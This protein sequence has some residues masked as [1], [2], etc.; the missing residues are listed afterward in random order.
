MLGPRARLAHVLDRDDDAKVELLPRAGVDDPDRARP[1]HE[2]SDFL[3]RALG[4]RQPDA[5]HRLAHEPVKP[6]D[7]EREVRPALR[8]GNRVDL[9]EDQRPGRPQHLAALR[10]EQQVERLRGRDQDVGR[11]AEHRR[12]LLLRGVAGPHGDCQLRLEPGERSAQVPLDVVVQRLQGRDVQE[13]QPLPRC[14]VE[15]VDPVEERRER[16]ARAGR[17][18][19]QRVLA[20]GDRG[21]AGLLGGHRR[22]ERPLEPLPRL[23]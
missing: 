13:A 3:D 11:L 21:P 10:G 15:L 9:V 14:R 5:L 20:R 8:P 18:L 16:L 12:A 17:R 22:C 6:L 4:R 7:R 19:D 1:R 2:A 23:R